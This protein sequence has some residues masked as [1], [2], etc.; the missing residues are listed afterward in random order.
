MQLLLQF[1][2]LLFLYEIC[3]A[4]TNTTHHSLQIGNSTLHFDHS[5]ELQ[6]PYSFQLYWTANPQSPNATFG[7]LA[8]T[9]APD[10]YVAVGFSPDGKMINSRALIAISS[11]TPSKNSIIN[12]V[13]ITARALYGLNSSHTVTF[14]RQVQYNSNDGTMAMAFSIPLS[15]GNLSFNNSCGIIYA[16]GHATS[17]GMIEKHVASHSAHIMLSGEVV[18]YDNDRAIKVAI[19]AGLMTLAWM[20][21]TPLAAFFASPQFRRRLFPKDKSSNPKYIRA[22]RYTIAVAIIAASVG[23]LIGVFVIGTRTFIVHFVLGMAVIGVMLVQASLG[24]WRTTIYPNRR[25]EYR[26]KG[27]E[28][29]GKENRHFIA[30]IHTWLGRML[31][32]MAVVNVV[33]GQLAYQDYGTVG[34]V[35][36]GMLAAV[37]CALFL[38]GPVSSIIT[39]GE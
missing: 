15:E 24:F 21:L 38:I 12:D 35:V 25:S 8:Q 2:L 10:G 34:L 30:L 26:V 32:A 7:V 14:N 37:G 13:K 39:R 33:F 28:K 18:D 20:I 3:Y 27:V 17:S 22:H 9:V 36:T 11:S 1:F 16:V 19:H 23:F 4:Q 31:Y 6:F 5:L 29:L